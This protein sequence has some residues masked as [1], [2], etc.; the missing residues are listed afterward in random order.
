[1]EIGL[2]K[3]GSCLQLCFNHGTSIQLFRIAASQFEVPL[4]IHDRVKCVH[5]NLHLDIL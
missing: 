2:K 1:M 3:M 4:K 5:S